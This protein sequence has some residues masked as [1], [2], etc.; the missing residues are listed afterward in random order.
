M[1]GATYHACAKGTRDKRMPKFRKVRA[2]LPFSFCSSTI[3]GDI[4]M[5]AD[6]K[7]EAKKQKTAKSLVDQLWLLQQ[8]EKVLNQA[9]ADL[10]EKL[11]KLLSDKPATFEGHEV[12]EFDS[13]VLKFIHRLSYTVKDADETRKVLDGS[14]A[15]DALLLTCFKP[16]FRVISSQLRFLN[17]AQKA[18]FKKLVTTKA[19]AIGVELVMDGDK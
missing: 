14:D 3:A 2:I 8:D 9:K 12:F 1:G 7:A 17:K 5:T 16:G 4:A 10:K 15:K 6:E 18:K 19:R 13:K 11:I